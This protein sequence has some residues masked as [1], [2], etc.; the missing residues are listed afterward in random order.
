[1]NLGMDKHVDVSVSFWDDEYNRV[2]PPK[3]VNFNPCLNLAQWW[4]MCNRLLCQLVG[5]NLQLVELQKSSAFLRMNM[6]FVLIE[7][8][9]YREHR[10]S[11]T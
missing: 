1:M 7:L 10:R 5:N 6:L 3:P 9:Q 11:K 8:R 2:L 4:V